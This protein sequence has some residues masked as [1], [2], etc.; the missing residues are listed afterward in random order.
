MLFKSLGLEVG[1]GGGGKLPE[2]LLVVH[3]IG[4]H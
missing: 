1:G 4:Y 2:S 3:K